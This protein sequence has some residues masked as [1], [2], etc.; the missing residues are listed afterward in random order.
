[1]VSPPNTVDLDTHLLPAIL[2][3][4]YRRVQYMR[5]PAQKLGGPIGTEKL[6]LLEDGVR[7]L[8]LLVA[9][10]STQPSPFGVVEAGNPVSK[11]G[12]S[13]SF[14][15]EKTNRHRAKK[16]GRGG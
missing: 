16:L 8:F 15:P 7:G 14:L 6:G 13:S 1:M 4:N 9:P 10:V 3:D 12:V 5:Q 2:T 11:S